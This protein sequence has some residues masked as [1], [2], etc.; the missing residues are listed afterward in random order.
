[1]D[2]KL[3]DKINF[4][5]EF[6]DWYAQIIEDFKF[7][8]IKECEARDY[9]T[10][11]F[12]KK[13]QKWNLETVLS[14]FKETITSKP[15]ILIYGCGPSLEKTFNTILKRKGLNFFKNFINI[16][17]D[18][19]STLLRK[20][21]VQIDAIFTDLDGITK[22][23]FNY[24]SFNV[25]HA[26]GDNIEKLKIFK[27]DIIKFENVIGTTQIEP[28]QNLL[29]PGGFTD[30]DRI[31]YFL[32]TLLSPFHTL[33]YIGMDFGSII[34]K[35]SKLDLKHDQ[36][37]NPTKLK[38]LQYAIKLMKWLSDKIENKIY[39]VNSECRTQDFTYLSIGDFL[40]FLNI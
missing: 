3:R 17:A 29:N 34:G 21:G 16:A 33:F 15:M 4:Y 31:L 2:S 30:G 9:L 10:Q 37:A 39:L 1:M 38:K 12:L 28:T 8:F 18:G 25:V 20:N 35:Y 5:Y 26:H 19:A 23:E 32:R 6:K 40:N 22:N 7:D 13:S 14:L 36:K 27:N 11:I 24:A